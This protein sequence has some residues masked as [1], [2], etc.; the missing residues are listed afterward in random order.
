MTL[1]EEWVRSQVA[2]RSGEA[3]EAVIESLVRDRFPLFSADT[4]RAEATR[5]FASVEGL[6]PLHDLLGDPEITDVLVNGPGRVWI[7]RAGRLQQSA[8]ELTERELNLLIERAFHRN[9]RSVDRA[10]PIGDTH[11]ADGTRLSV[12]LPPL[13]PHGP[14]V[15]LR[16]Q[17]DERIGLTA[18]GEGLVLDTLREAVRDRQNVLVYGATGAGKTTLLAAMAS[19]VG[20]DER[21][22]TIEDAA[23]LRIDHPHVVA[24]ERRP[25]NG[26][27]R[28]A[29]T[30]RDLVG[31]SLRLRPDRLVLG[32]ARGGEA[33]DVVWALA[34]GHRGSFATVHAASG[35]GAL[36][37]LEVFVAM[38]D[39]ALPH[40]VI[41]A[42]VRGAFDLAVGVARSENGRRV[43]A[44]ERIIARRTHRS[45]VETLWAW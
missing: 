3:V 25:D 45:G 20:A 36:E 10:H 8:L 44:I 35:A 26:E 12:V 17:R 7:E 19:L 1:D 41:R 22:V 39:A 9:G 4:V 24:L 33:L 13:A 40:S 23:E 14:V 15:A 27:G 18:F 31:A 32:E 16:R 5:L 29:V 43:V 21:I 34:S 11:L 6:G 28:G 37:R 38:A 42:Q 2:E 30:L